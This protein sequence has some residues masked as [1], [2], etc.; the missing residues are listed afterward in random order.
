MA[1]IVF[2]GPGYWCVDCRTA[3]ASPC[4]KYPGECRSK[5]CHVIRI[6]PGKAKY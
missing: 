1:Y 2:E 4:S 3:S 5:E 6:T